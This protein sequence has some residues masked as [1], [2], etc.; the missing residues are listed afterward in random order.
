MTR[1][2]I[3]TASVGGVIHNIKLDLDLLPSGQIRCNKTSGDGTTQAYAGEEII[4]TY[5]P[6]FGVEFL[7]W[8]ITN[9]TTL[10]IEIKIEN[11]LT[12][13]MPD[14]DIRVSAEFNDEPIDPIDPLDPPH[15]PNINTG[16]SGGT[17]N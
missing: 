4:L 15:T 17:G 10:E 6:D 8:S 7:N 2:S 16:H 11:P 1:R 14:S 13:I 12:Y 3:L 9:L 5:V